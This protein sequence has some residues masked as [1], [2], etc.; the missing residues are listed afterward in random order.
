MKYEGR[1][2]KIQRQPPPPPKKKKKTVRFWTHEI[3]LFPT[4]KQRQ[5][6]DVGNMTYSKP[7]IWPEI[8]TAEQYFILD[9]ENI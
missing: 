6:L 5:I 8:R 9:V 1:T 2:T 7:Y 3:W 4:A